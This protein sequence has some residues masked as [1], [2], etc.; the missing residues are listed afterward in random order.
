MTQINIPLTEGQV[1]YHLVLNKIIKVKIQYIDSNENGIY[2]YGI[3]I[4][5]NGEIEQPYR[6][7]LITY[8]YG[9]THFG[10]EVFFTENE[11]LERISL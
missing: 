2:I 9:K 4:P 7:I 11:A 3:S 8:K 6:F 1:L 10:R 5:E